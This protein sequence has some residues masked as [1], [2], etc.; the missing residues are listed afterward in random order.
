M[1]VIIN[2]DALLDDYKKISKI[3]RTNYIFNATDSP[4]VRD[5]GNVLTDF[6]ARSDTV[7]AISECAFQI[8]RSCYDANLPEKT[9]QKK[10]D[11]FFDDPAF[12]QNAIRIVSEQI[13]KPNSNYLIA[14][15]NTDYET[16]GNRY[17]EAFAEIM[18]LDNP[19][20]VVFLYDDT[21]G[22]YKYTQNQLIKKLNK[23]D[24]ALEENDEDDDLL[25]RRDDIV[26]ALNTLDVADDPETSNK[27]SKK[28]VRKVFLNNAV[29]KKKVL[30]KLTGRIEE[31]QKI[32]NKSSNPYANGRS[33]DDDDDD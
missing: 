19:S 12:A 8:P 31:Y 2:K 29:I 9:V 4:K 14:L 24:D 27:K 7:S 25:D 6:D 26:D 33:Y 11:A 3:E 16:F 20:D 18:G 13:L 1:I 32:Q 30:K 10:I 22:M 5:L 15:T 28:I 23:I 21:R 17:L